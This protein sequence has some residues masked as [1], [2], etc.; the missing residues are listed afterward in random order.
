[1]N[2]YTISFL[3]LV[4]LV[5]PTLVLAETG[6]LEKTRGLVK[7]RNI[8]E[9]IQKIET[10]AEEKTKQIEERFKARQEK[11][12]ERSKKLEE[13]K[14]ETKKNFCANV[15]ENISERQ[16]EF[17]ERQSEFLEKKTERLAERKVD[18]GET[19]SQIAEKRTAAA[20][21]RAQMYQNLLSKATTD[22]QKAAVAVFQTSIEKAV[23]DREAALDAAR[24]AFH[25]GI[26]TARSS[27]KMDGSEALATFRATMQ[28]ALAKVKTECEEGADQNAIRT[29]YLNTLEVARKNLSE[30]RQNNGIGD[31]VSQLAETRIAAV[32]TALNTYRTAVEDASKLLKEAFPASEGTE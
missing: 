1:M 25:T 21:R 4:F 12:S 8:P 11:E 13:R 15:A 23:R 10:K 7:E 19:D 32:R 29:E 27:R 6:V 26:D 2:K 17:A 14:A 16:T 28:T 20:E 18:R 30:N 5:V 3:L 24:T 22:E 9:R 31:T